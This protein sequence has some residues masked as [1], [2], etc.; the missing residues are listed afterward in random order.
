MRILAATLSA[1][2][3][4]AVTPPRAHAAPAA[5]AA[6]D[7]HALL[8]RGIALHREAAYASS[9]TALALDRN[10]TVEYWAELRAPGGY[11]QTGSA[12]RPLELPIGGVPF[13][14][15][16]APAREHK[17]SVLTSWWLWTAV[18][19]VAATGLGVGLY[20]ALRPN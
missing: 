11:A 19:A 8:Q 6:M 12:E 15:A 7:G 2:L 9:V 13:A 20:F 17:R 10:G 14:L 4:V 5:P 18:G 3:L 16:A 1:L